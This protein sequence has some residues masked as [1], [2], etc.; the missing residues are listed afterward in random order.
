MPPKLSMS[1]ALMVPAEAISPLFAIALVVVVKTPFDVTLSTPLLFK[2]PGLNTF[3]DPITSIVPPKSFL[4]L[5]AS[6]V[7]ETFIVPEFSKPFPLDA[8]KLP[9]EIKLP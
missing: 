7:P 6:I 4:N 5:R 2:S 8:Y 3:R 9:V 1:T